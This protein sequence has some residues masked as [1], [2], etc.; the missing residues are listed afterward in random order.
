M[1][2]VSNLVWPQ[3]NEDVCSWHDTEFYRRVVHNDK[4]YCILSVQ[5]CVI[6]IKHSVL[7]IIVCVIVL[8]IAGSTVGLFTQHH[9][10]YLNKVVMLQCSRD[11]DIIKQ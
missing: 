7:C 6:T 10:K 5:L 11:Q 3:G 1:V 9:H 8:S 4:D 2:Y